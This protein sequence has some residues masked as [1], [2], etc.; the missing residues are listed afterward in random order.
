MTESIFLSYSSTADSGSGS[1]FALGT[2]TKINYTDSNG[3]TLV[4]KAGLDRPHP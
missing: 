2:H 1:G 4:L 3:N